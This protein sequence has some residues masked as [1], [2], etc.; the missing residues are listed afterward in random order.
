MAKIQTSISDRKNLL[1][2]LQFQVFDSSTALFG[3]S[4]VLQ[5]QANAKQAAPHYQLVFCNFSTFAKFPPFLC[6]SVQNITDCPRLL[7]AKATMATSSAWRGTPAQ[8][9]RVDCRRLCGF[10]DPLCGLISRTSSSPGELIFHLCWLLLL[11]SQHT[12]I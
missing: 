11:R 4:L 2:Q 5:A 8:V 12:S 9:S 1:V 10:S 6:L 7:V 3:Q